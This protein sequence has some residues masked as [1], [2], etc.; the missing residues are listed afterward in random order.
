[1]TITVP[2]LANEVKGWLKVPSVPRNCALRLR[3]YI[4]LAGTL[5]KSEAEGLEA[6]AS[7]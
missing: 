7:E 1:M 3:G 4:K 2:I 5:P 6:S